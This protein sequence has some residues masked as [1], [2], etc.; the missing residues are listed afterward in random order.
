MGSYPIEAVRIA[1][2]ELS[3]S[4][5]AGIAAAG[6][7]DGVFVFLGDMPLVPRDVAGQLAAIL[8]DRFAAVPR[9]AGQG[10]HPVLLSRRAFGDVARL[11]GDRGA[12]RLL[13]GRGDIAFLDDAGEGCLLDVDRAADL[14]RLDLPGETDA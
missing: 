8:D 2:T 7:A 11:A 6:D 10:G 13:A 5:K 1:S 9:H 3:A 14:R 12:G 4:L